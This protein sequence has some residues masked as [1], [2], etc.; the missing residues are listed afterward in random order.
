[1]LSV[2]LKDKVMEHESAIIVGKHDETPGGCRC[3]AVKTQVPNLNGSY[4]DFKV[5]LEMLWYL[6]RGLR[7]DEM[8]GAIGSGDHE[9]VEGELTVWRAGWADGLDD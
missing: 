7:Q 4:L 6:G 8:D 3:S 2:D 5:E 1:M 9:G